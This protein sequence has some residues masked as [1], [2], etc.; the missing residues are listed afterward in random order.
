MSKK[1]LGQFMTTNYAY[2][3]QNLKIPENIKNVIE[4]FAGN[5]D[6]IEFV[7]SHT[8]KYNIECYDIEPKKEF[9]IKKDTF[10]SPPNYNNFYV[11][12]NPP[13]LSI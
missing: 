4:P 12:T 10:L 8:Q 1:E 13:F 9:I 3:L 5:G 7:K 11:V 6:L 2:I